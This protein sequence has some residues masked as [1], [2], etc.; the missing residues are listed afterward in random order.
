VFFRSARPTPQI[1][2]VGTHPC[3]GR[4]G[5]PGVA[6]AVFATPLF[7]LLADRLDIAP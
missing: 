5:E 3:S 2:N 7:G 1:C 6:T 4:P